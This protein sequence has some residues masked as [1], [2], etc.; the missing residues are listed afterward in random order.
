MVAAETGD[1]G[2]MKN[3][4]CKTTLGH[5][6]TGPPTMVCTRGMMSMS[7]RKSQGVIDLISSIFLMTCEGKTLHP[8]P[9][10]IGMALSSQTSN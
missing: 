3:R 1:V 2:G 9:I 7:E 8:N 6:H 4:N 10:F 5:V